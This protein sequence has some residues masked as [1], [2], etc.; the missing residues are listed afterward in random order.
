MQLI[1]SKLHDL[2]TRHLKEIIIV[3]M[4]IIAG[5]A[6]ILASQAATNAVSIE[7]EDGSKTG[8]ISVVGDAN[9]SGGSVVRFK[10]RTQSQLQGVWSVWIWDCKRPGV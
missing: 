8:N 7:A 6:T 10:W 2:T 3:V 1:N 9:A 4:F 5:V